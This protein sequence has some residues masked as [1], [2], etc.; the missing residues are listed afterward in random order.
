VVS[1]LYLCLGPYLFDHLLGGGVDA[2]NLLHCVDPLAE[3]WGGS[4]VHGPWGGSP[5]HGP[6][7]GSPVHIPARTFATI[8]PTP[9]PP[10]GRWLCC[11]N[12]I[13]GSITL[14]NRLVDE[15]T[16]DVHEVAPAHRRQV[17]QCPQEVGELYP[18]PQLLPRP[19]CSGAS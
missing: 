9:V 7:G 18:L 2:R 17:G 13:P 10:N 3:S 1:M 14:Q 19:G 8:P 15:R 5:V 4:P 11:L 12:R 6:G 16:G